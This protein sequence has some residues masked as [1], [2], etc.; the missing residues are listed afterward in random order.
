MALRV[1]PGPIFV[2]ESLILARRRQVYAG[3][4]LFVFAILIALATAWYGTGGRPSLPGT[5]GG[6]AATLEMLALAGQK[7][8]YAMAAIQ[9]AMV[10]LV[11]PAATAGAIC[12]DRAQG[13]LAQLAVTDLSDS[14]I[15]LGKLGSRLAPILGLLACG[16][17][18][19]ALAALLGGIDPQALFSLFAVSVAIAVLGC[20][21]ALAI[22][23]RAARTHEVLIA[24]L[25]LWILWLLSLPIWEGASTISG[26]VPPPDWFRKANPFVL[27][28]ATIFVLITIGWPLFFTAVIWQPLHDWLL[29]YWDP[30]DGDVRWLPEGMMVISP[31][32]AP[33]FTLEWILDHPWNWNSRWRFWLIASAWCTLAAA[34]AAAMFWAALKSFDRCLGRMPE[35]SLSR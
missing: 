28:Y 10:L 23:V 34:F 12:H 35:T 18:V 7:F 27:V 11:A 26:V 4:S 1:G 16:L 20:S 33:M 6:P 21:L 24:V 8:F 29:E 9:L 22:S 15:V 13:I 31:F 3:R 17:P 30:M 2:F 32:F 19:T 14:E 25:A 5:A